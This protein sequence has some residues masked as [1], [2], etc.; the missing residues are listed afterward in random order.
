MP[1]DTVIFVILKE[2]QQLNK[3]L[4]E[5]AKMQYYLFTTKCTKVYWHFR[6]LYTRELTILKF[7]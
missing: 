7:T 2:S 1:D 5:M 4:P 3:A 6:Y